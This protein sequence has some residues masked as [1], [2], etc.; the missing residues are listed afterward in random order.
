MQLCDLCHLIKNEL[1]NRTFGCSHILSKV[2]IAHVSLPKF[3]GFPVLLEHE[4]SRILIV[5]VQIV[6]Y[7]AF[8]CAGDVNQLEKFSLYQINLVSFGLDVCNDS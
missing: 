6:V 5:L 7:A 2:L 4:V 8:F 1:F 3:T